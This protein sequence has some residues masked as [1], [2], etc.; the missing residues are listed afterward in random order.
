MSNYALDCVELLEKQKTV[1]EHQARISYKA[2]GENNATNPYKKVQGQ[3]VDLLTLTLEEYEKAIIKNSQKTKILFYPNNA[4]VMVLPS[5]EMYRDKID[6][7]LCFQEYL[8]ELISSFND[9]SAFAIQ[10]LDKEDNVLKSWLITRNKENG[11]MYM[12]GAC[13]GSAK[14]VD[15]KINGGYGEYIKMISMLIHISMKYEIKNVTL[16][17]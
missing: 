11:T 12:H 14:N 3:S 7:S 6:E 13:E 5:H 4:F 16:Y 8:V 2:L 17:N 10:Y 9:L 1:F 15:T